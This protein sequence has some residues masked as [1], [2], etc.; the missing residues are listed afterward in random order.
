ML[1]LRAGTLT[2]T[3]DWT[4]PAG[5]RVRV[6][7]TRLVSLTQRAV[8]AIEYVVEPVDGPVRAIVQSELVANETQPRELRD[9]DPRVAAVLERPLEPV[10]HQVRGS[11]AVL[12]HRT[13]RSDLQMAA[14]MDHEIEA[15]GRARRRHTWP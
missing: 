7:S 6:R 13:R 14:G 12:V 5:Q 8:A 15:P 1:D 10:E 11:G 9:A 2:R 4:S 3:V